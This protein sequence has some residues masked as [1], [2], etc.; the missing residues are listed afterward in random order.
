M[1][2]SNAKVVNALFTL[3]CGMFLS[4]SASAE[5]VTLRTA[6][7][8]A[9]E[10]SAGDPDGTG[11]A[12]I[13]IDT[14]TGAVRWAITAANIDPVTGAHIHQA[15][16]G[17]NG[18]IVVD[19]A[20]Q[21][22]GS[23][24]ITTTLANDIANNPA[25]FYVNV[26]TAPTFPA[27]AIRGQLARVNVQGAL[28]NTSLS[29]ANEVPPADPDGSGSATVRINPLTG[30]LTW[31]VIA[32]NISP[33]TVAHIHRGAA[34]A[35]GPVVVNFDG[36]L[37]GA[38]TI[39]PTLAAEI[40]ANPAGFYVNIHSTEYAGG[41]IRG[42]LASTALAGVRLAA[43]LAGSSEV[44]PTSTGDP[45]GSGSASVV[46][47]AAG[48][49]I[50]WNIS[51]T[52]ILLPPTLVHIHRGVAGANGPVVVDFQAQLSGTGTISTA[53]ANEILSN[54]AGFYINVH[55]SEFPGGAIRGQLAAFAS[56][57][58]PTLNHWLLLALTGLLLAS[59]AYF[60]R[61]STARSGT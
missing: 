22:T 3:V 55:T 42:Q 7:A 53:L 48:G 54:P 58:V 39:T 2:F 44:P 35:N 59:A 19:F 28:L 43:P 11:N 37:V 52:N 31:D 23:A 50:S 29:G 14:T 12:V 8:G 25:G 27:G 60:G 45:D 33:V 24:T 51:T 5:I 16:A 47:D 4:W 13:N 17:V 15:A 38:T 40:V 56:P 6:L 49:V 26:H 1:Y 32:N 46:I 30:D 21:L 10:V 9:N 61:V 34:G 18:P 20:G 57:S 41:A 36:K